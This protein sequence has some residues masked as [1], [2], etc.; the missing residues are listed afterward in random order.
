M[1]FNLNYMLSFPSSTIKKDGSLKYP[2]TAKAIKEIEEKEEM[3]YK[4]RM[5]NKEAE[6]RD[7]EID[8]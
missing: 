6:E 5:K 8:M 4:E 1:I 7:E 2:L 3:E